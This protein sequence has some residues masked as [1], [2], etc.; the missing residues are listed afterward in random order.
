[1]DRYSDLRARAVEFVAEWVQWGEVVVLAPVREA[2]DEVALAACGDALIGVHR[3]AFRELALEL[4]AAELNRRALTPV[5]RVVRE[6]LAARVT[7]EAAGAGKLSY[8]GPVAAFPGFPRALADTFEELRLNGIPLGQLRECGQSGADL[9]LL[10]GAYEDEL[11]ARGFADHA[12]RVELARLG[13]AGLLS[14]KAVVALDLAPRTRSERELLTL[15]LNTARAHLDLR[16]GHGDTPPQSSLELLQRYLFSGDAVPGREEDGSVAIFSTSGEAL[17]CVE[18]ARRIGAAVDRG[19]PY[20]QIAIAVRSPERYQPL[21]V[22][23]LR[24]AG[25]PVHCTR[26]SRRPDVAGRSFLALLHCAEERLSASRFA[27]YLSLGQMPDDEEPRTPAAWERLLVDAAVIG[28]PDRWETRLHGLREELHRRYREEEDEGERAR[29]ERRV[30]SLENL[31]DFALPVIG[32]L[33]ALP[34]RAT[35]GEWITALSDLAEFTLREP[36]RVTALVEELEPMSAIGPVGLGQVLLVIGPRLG[37]LTAAPKES[38][39]GKVWVGGIE[40]ARGMAFRCVFV[41]GVNEGLFPRPPAEDPLLLEAQRQLLGIELRAEDTELLRIAA[42][43]AGEQFTLSFSRLDLLTGRLRVPSFYAFAAHRA[44]GGGEI[45]VREFEARARSATRT[46]IGWPAPPDPADAIDDAEFDLATLA[47]LVKGSGEYLKSLP[48][49]AVPSLRARW[50]RWHKSWKPADGLFIE[51]IGSDALKAYRLTERAWSPSLLQQ[52][53]RCP[54]RFA[55]R[56]VFGLRPAERPAGIQRMDPAERGNLYHAVQFELLRDL[57]A[58]GLVPVNGENLA[59][60]LERLDAVLRMEAARAAAELAPAIPQIWRAEVQS[61]RADLRGWL[62]QKALV[63]ADWTPEFNELSFGLKSPAGRD[64]RSLREP[65][66]VSGG[67][68]L[69]GSIDLVERRAGGMLRVV[70]HKIGR[71]PDPRPETVGKGEVL[72]PTLYALAAEAMLGEAVAA[73]RLYYSTIAQNYTP[74][75]VPMHDWTRRRAQH[76]LEVIDGAIVNGT[77]PAAPREDG[78]RNCEYLPIC[79]PYEEER[80]KEKS[81]VELQSLKEVRSWK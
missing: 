14:E 19:V 48:G 3:L 23:G 4:S 76:V 35:W 45:D 16:L 39:Y 29:L 24:R 28:G 41:P 42:A 80:V 5:G 53:A 56:G 46:R 12:A 7:E 13:T 37:S 27:E 36:E 81:Q 17:E 47:P 68:Q 49:R 59:A 32:R 79:G 9:A 57:A 78:C 55:L 44:A 10:L 20:D 62:Q 63:E 22:E 74:I 6:A 38:R 26:G 70:D 21:V 2:A 69:Q 65:V 66:T 75:D 25:I 50:A 31:R 60:A 15:V 11:A 30:A 61:L 43:S 67:Y 58:A 64:P 71:I 34:E 18:I 54:Y 40:E 33:A 8:L 51:E 72:Q 1:M 73:G 77:L 52:Y